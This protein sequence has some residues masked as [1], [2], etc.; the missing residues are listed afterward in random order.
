[1]LWASVDLALWGRW[2]MGR[3]SWAASAAHSNKGYKSPGSKNVENLKGNMVTRE[4]V[5]ISE[6]TR[7]VCDMRW[8]LDLENIFW[9]SHM[10]V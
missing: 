5:N 10:L 7:V 1:M 6:V 4:P 8:T 2:L 3:A 9:R